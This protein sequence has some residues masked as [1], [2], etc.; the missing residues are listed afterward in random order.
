M[1]MIFSPIKK[2][3]TSLKIFLS[4]KSSWYELVF[5]VTPSSFKERRKRALGKIKQLTVLGKPFFAN[6]IENAIIYHHEVFFSDQ[7]HA[8]E[9]IKKGFVVIDAGANIGM[10]SVLASSLGAKVYAFE[11]TKETYET[12]VRNIGNGIAI[13]KGLGDEKSFKTLISF[14][15]E[16]GGNIL[17]DSPYY[18]NQRGAEERIEVTTIDDF[19]NENAV[20]RVDFI[21]IDT[22]GYE[23]K[24][25]KGAANTIKKYKPVIAM[26]AY[27][28]PNDK[29]DLPLLLKSICPGYVC[30]LHNEVEEDF[31]CYFS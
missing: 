21:K 20:G 31:I 6:N 18:K 4:G 16:S 15:S 14:A 3:W 7:Y 27:H 12:L 25:L 29:E 11:P 23:A 17:S 30:K 2:R 9:Y 5:F 8:R 10:F 22:E 19:I 28:N 26:S 13:N 24:I 1:S